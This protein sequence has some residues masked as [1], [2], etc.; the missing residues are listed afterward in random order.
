[1][2]PQGTNIGFWRIVLMGMIPGGGHLYLGR[3]V[4]AIL[5]FSV[6]FVI[7]GFAVFAMGKYYSSSSRILS[8]GLFKQGQLALVIGI[9]LWLLSIGD[10][11]RLA[12]MSRHPMATLRLALTWQE[13]KIALPDLGLAALFVLALIDYSRPLFPGFSIWPSYVFWGFF[14]ILALP[15][16][17]GLMNI[18]SSPR[19]GIGSKA[20]SVFIIVLVFGWF[21]YQMDTGFGVAFI[22]FIL[23][24]A[25][26]FALGKTTKED[27]L[28]IEKRAGLCFA[29][30]FLSG[31]VLLLSKLYLS[32]TDFPLESQ[33]GEL[34]MLWMG[35]DYF[36]ILA[37]LEIW[38]L[39]RQ[40]QKLKG[41]N[42]DDKRV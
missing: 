12:R 1:M 20:F 29:G 7:L 39:R 23:A 17:P 37:A 26:G 14:E 42:T 28:H 21:T 3:S 19:R 27:Q 8:Y 24:K 25:I 41:E 5:V 36:I 31:V 18:F 11:L 34:E 40:L 15:V 22:L 6:L 10:A 4:R 33:T 38:W 30:F 32:W 35:L 13:F 2:L 9:P 16:A